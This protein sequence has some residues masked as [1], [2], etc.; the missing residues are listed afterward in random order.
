MS[1]KTL[2]AGTDALPCI[3]SHI[4]VLPRYHFARVSQD[5]LDEPSLGGECGAMI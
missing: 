2:E 3:I 1:N 5:D 4:S